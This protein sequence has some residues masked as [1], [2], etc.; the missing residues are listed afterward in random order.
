MKP[1]ARYDMITVDNTCTERRDP[2]MKQPIAPLLQALQAYAHSDAVPMHMPG[3]KRNTQFADYLS[4]LG[5]GFDITEIHGFDDLHQPEGILLD[6]MNKAAALWNSRKAFYLINGSTCGIL[7]GIRAAAGQGSSVILTRGC[8]KSVYHAIELCDLTPHYLSPALDETFGIMGSITP[9]QVEQAIVECP[10]A[11]LLILTSPTYEG[12]LSDL[13]RICELAHKA[14]IPVL[15]DEAHGAHLGLAEGW[16]QGA[17]DA[18]ADLVVQSLH[19]TLPSL[20]Q[21]ALMHVNG[22]LISAD[23]V[24]RQLGIFETSS[25]SYLLL[26]S[27]DGCVEYLLH[28]GTQAFVQWREYLTIFSESVK[29]LQHLK[30][31]FYGQDSLTQHPT[32]FAHDPS[33]LVISCRGTSITGPELMQQL[34]QGYG[35]ELEMA[36]GDYVI[37]MTGLGDTMQ[38]LAALS[39]A[40][41]AIDKTLQSQPQKQ[42]NPPSLPIPQRICS[43]DTAL[44]SSTVCTPLE[45]CIGSISAEYVWAYPPGIP[46]LVPGEQIDQAC[47]D[48]CLRLM[49]QGISLRSTSGSLPDSLLTLSPESV[50]AQNAMFLK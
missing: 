50:V 12:V 2:F 37:A 29:N 44:R 17:V 49:Q 30:I 46:L 45:Q 31:L 26:S 28:N 22:S 4:V 27:I 13:P 10:H 36:S 47:L 43:V 40:L 5:A 35:I 25:P 42:L 8:H 19:K 20:T 39:H 6:S 15:V 21:T 11:K 23:A 24:A 34:R 1:F 38:N 16:P 3:H 48:T 41:C 14:G 32:F 33:K 9:A 7:A 18:G